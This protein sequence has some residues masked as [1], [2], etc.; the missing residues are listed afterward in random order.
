MQSSDLKNKMLSGAIW[1]SMDRLGLQGF[2]FILQ[3][4][5]AR[6]LLPADF[7]IVVLLDVFIQIAWCFIDSGLG[8]S[9]V[10]CREAE[11]K[12]FSGIYWLSQGIAVVCY[13]LL[14]FAAPWIAEFYRRPPLSTMLRVTALSLFFVAHTSICSAIIQRKL[15]FKKLFFIGFPATVAGGVLGGTLAW[16]G[17]G[18]WSLVWMQLSTSFFRLLFSVFQ[19]RWLPRFSFNWELTFKMFHFGYIILI[20]N[21]ISAL[22]ERLPEF[23]IGR[24]FPVAQLGY[25]SKAY[26]IPFFIASGVSHGLGGTTFPALTANQA[27]FAMQQKI[28]ARGIEVIYFVLLPLL[29]FAAGAGYNI[30]FILLGEKWLP[31]VPYMQIITSNLFFLPLN[32]LNE[33]VIIANGRKKILLRIG[34]ITRIL[35]AGCFLI[36]IPGGI[37]GMLWGL[38]A[39]SF[40]TFL[41]LSNESRKIIQ[42]GS[43][44]QLCI[45]LRCSFCAVSAGFFCGISPYFAPE[46]NRILLF[47]FQGCVFAIIY[48]ITS[49]LFNRSQLRYS[50]NMLKTI[51]DKILF[52]SQATAS[53]HCS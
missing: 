52:H 53:E 25:Y 44:K 13:M 20:F 50:V 28:V 10:Q 18:A 45:I 9:M 21:V 47:M 3:I 15:Q 35:S 42:L 37:R 30:I 29:A 31:C 38:T 5:L 4:I 24:L 23:V 16:L 2:N 34:L 12:D 6:L 36:G 40:L 51:F 27:D 32:K 17:L 14:F 7:G 19:T 11:E 33:E 26:K 46:I 41:L 8:A 22:L 1:Q 39:G 49:F 48:L 43:W